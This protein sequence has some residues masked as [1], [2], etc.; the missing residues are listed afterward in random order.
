MEQ[1]D[2]VVPRCRLELTREKFLGLQR[3]TGYS[4]SKSTR[5]FIEDA[6]TPIINTSSTRIFRHDA[7]TQEQAHDAPAGKMAPGSP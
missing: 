4:P 6:T 3:H 1:A 2:E 5:H 7:Q